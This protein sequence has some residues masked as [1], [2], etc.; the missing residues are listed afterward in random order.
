MDD[1][2]MRAWRSR[3]N[4]RYMT[5]EEVLGAWDAAWQIVSNIMGGDWARKNLNP[6]KFNRYLRLGFPSEDGATAHMRTQR[7]VQ[8]SKRLYDLRTVEGYSDMIERARR[9]SLLGLVAE[10]NAATILLN[11]G[12]GVRFRPA[13]GTARDYDLSLVVNGVEIA[14]EVKAKEETGT[15]DPF[16]ESSLLNTL[17]DS[18]K[19]LPETGPS[20]VFVAVPSDWITHD[21]T[22]A[23]RSTITG[24]LRSTRRVNAVVVM[25]DIRV[26]AGG[27]GMGFA[28]S[29]FLIPNP[30]PRTRLRN[31]IGIC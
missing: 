31:V 20:L 4:G 25:A 22:A 1:G 11:R 9:D 28:T 19:Q 13:T 3:L 29:H 27:G 30:K 2:R 7:L 17:K 24:W 10:L 26:H 23:L 8:L 21:P 15:G 12:H 18:R 5:E 16:K 6:A 14:V